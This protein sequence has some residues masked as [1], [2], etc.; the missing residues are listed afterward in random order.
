MEEARNE[1]EDMQD[2]FEN[3][4]LYDCLEETKY[5]LDNTMDEFNNVNSI[6]ENGELDDEFEK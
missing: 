1:I 6:Y 5:S 3:D 4:R 2:S